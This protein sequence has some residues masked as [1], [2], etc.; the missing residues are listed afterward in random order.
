MKSIGTL[1]KTVSTL[2][3]VISM[4]GVA[5][6]QT[7]APPVQTV[8]TTSSVSPIIYPA[9]GQTQE[10]MDRDKAECQTWA[11]QQ[12]GYDPLVAGLQAQPQTVPSTQPVPSQ[13]RGGA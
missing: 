11:T 9:K 12:S 5:V 6:A 10:Q 3:I 4:L 8:Q 1:Q 2:G 13:P 7:P